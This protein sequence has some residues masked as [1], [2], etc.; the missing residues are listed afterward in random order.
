MAVTLALA[1]LAGG[2]Y[3]LLRRRGAGARRP[4]GADGTQEWRCACGQA[5]RVAGSDRHRVYW[6]RDAPEQEPVL[7]GNCPSCDRPLPAE[8]AATTV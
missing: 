2:G 5:F 1:A 4:R 3:L 7:S 6:L 8:H